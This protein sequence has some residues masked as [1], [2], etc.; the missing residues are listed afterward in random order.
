M[1]DDEGAA[2]EFFDLV[3]A[4]SIIGR[5]PVRRVPFRTRT[6]TLDEGARVEWRDEGAAYRTSPLKVTSQTG[7]DRFD[8]GAF[9]VVS[10]EVLEDQSVDAEVI[11]RNDLVKALASAI[12]EAFINPANSGSAG[13][14]PAAIT[15]GASA[16]SPAEGLFEWGDTFTGDPANAWII[17]HPFTAARLNS[18]ARPNIGADGGTWAGFKVLT[19]TAHPE[20]SFTFVDP[21]QVAVA[22]GNPEVRVSD[23]TSVEMVDSSSMTSGPSV[24]A[25]NLVSMFQVNCAAI[26]ASLNANW[27]VVRPEAVQVFDVQAYGL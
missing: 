19:S 22:M 21:D 7:L 15:S 5:L 1:V 4:R 16:D 9:I 8:V 26:A 14:K 18:A 6:L 17:A 20:G 3:R 27:R 24:S 25:S 2:A 11:V 12:D 23:E 10:K 13:V